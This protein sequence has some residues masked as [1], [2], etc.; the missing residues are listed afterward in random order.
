MK[1]IGIILSGGIGSRFNSTIPKQ[2]LNLN[3]K[4][5]ISYSIEAFRKSNKIDDFIVVVDQ[6]EYLSKNIENKYGVKCIVGGISRNWSLYNAINYIKERYQCCENIFIHEA[7]RP[8]I[9]SKIIDLY[10]SFLLEYDAVITTKHITD[11]LGKEGEQ[12]IDRSKYYL[13]QAPEAFKFNLLTKYFSKDSSI[14]ATVQ[15]LPFDIKI[16]KY[17]EFYNNYKITYPED[18]IIAEQ[19][20]NTFRGN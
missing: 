12:F 18:L 15:Q 1:N 3:D 4:E 17:Y 16:K 13:I 5:I 20:M 9:L 2:Y 7:A 19:I 8:F 10:L 11:S 6:S 14:T